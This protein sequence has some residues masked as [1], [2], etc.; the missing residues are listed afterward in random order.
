[1]R[2]CLCL[3]VVAGTFLAGAS[4]ARA[5]AR[6]DE[7]RFVFDVG[8]GIDPSINGNVN[9]GAIGTLQNQATAMLP[10]SYGDVYGTGIQFRFGGGYRLNEVSE[11]RGVFTYQSADAD[12]V[13]LGDIGP[14]SLY[15]QYSDYKSIG[16]DVGYRRYLSLPGRNFR[17]Y[18]EGTIGLAFVNSID[19]QFAAPQ[20]NALFNS[21]DFYDDSGA[22]T[23][24]INVGVL[25]PIAEKIDLNGQVGLRRVG[26]LSEVDQ[27]VGTG[28]DDLNSDSARITL[29]FVVGLRFRF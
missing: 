18:G 7:S 8:V 28:L 17:V 2:I 12:L 21:T 13:R 3:C 29:P 1:M 4:P 6:P 20:S 23:W 11:L 15:A 16:L 26:G 25:V 5:Q 10:N 24:G 9:S 22:F 27:L 19:A 14:S